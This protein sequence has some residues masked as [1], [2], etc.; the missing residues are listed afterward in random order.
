MNFSDHFIKF[1]ATCT[2]VCSHSHERV[3]KYEAK[4]TVHCV[5]IIP[6]YFPMLCLLTN[7]Y[8]KL[9]SNAVCEID[10]GMQIPPLSAKKH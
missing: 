9:K 10:V 7:L 4:N 1:I 2:K 8:G 5:E 6:F 3:E